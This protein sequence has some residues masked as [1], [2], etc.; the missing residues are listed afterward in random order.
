[1]DLIVQGVFAELLTEAMEPALPERL[2]SYRKSFSS[3]IAVRDFAAYVREHRRAIREPRERGLFVL[4]ADVR[5]YGDS[6]SMDERSALWAQV[7]DVLGSSTHDPAWPLVRDIVRPAVLT[8]DGAVTRPAFGVATGSPVATAVANLYLTDLDRSLQRI[9]WGFYARYGDDVL[10]AHPDPEKV[11]EVR[12]LATTRLDELGLE[13]N[14]EKCRLLFFNGAGRPAPKRSG[15]EGSSRV[16]YLGCNID[17]Q[18]TVGLSEKKRRE[19][20]R[21]VRRRIRRTAKAIGEHGCE[22]KGR[23][24]C[25]VVNTALDPRA[26]TSVSHSPLLASAVSD[27]QQLKDLD[28][29]IARAIAEEV[30][31]RRGSRAFRHI[32]FRKIRSNWRLE[33]LVVRRNRGCASAAVAS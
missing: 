23:L 6:I 10:F 27:R 28:F 30:S 8:E 11:H 17:F 3:W 4:R 25:A 14:L 26:E 12:A 9:P 7:A 21:E 22:E 13:L 16:T 31:Q 20:L 32:P 2:Y 19:T 24:L 29:R 15:F 18:G 33:S 5:D 1:V